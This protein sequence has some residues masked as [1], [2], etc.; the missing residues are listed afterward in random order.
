MADRRQARLA[1]AN[2]REACIATWHG[3]E[4]QKNAGLCGQVRYYHYILGINGA[5]HCS[6]ATNSM[7]K[8]QYIVYRNG[9]KKRIRGAAPCH[10]PLCLCGLVSWGPR[11]SGR[12]AIIRRPRPHRP[13]RRTTWL[14]LTLSLYCARPHVYLSVAHPSLVH[15][16]KRLVYFRFLIQDVFVGCPVSKTFFFVSISLSRSVDDIIPVPDPTISFFF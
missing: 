16:P 15:V 4:E 7:K 2:K 9:E 1:T 12:R 14:T 13:R 6:S 5:G 3:L 8:K 10:W 11:P